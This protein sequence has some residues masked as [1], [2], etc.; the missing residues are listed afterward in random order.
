MPKKTVSNLEA[1]Q[2]SRKKMTEHERQA[3]EE[4][5]LAEREWQQREYEERRTVRKKLAEEAEKTGMVLRDKEQEE[6]LRKL[7][8][9]LG[10][11]KES[12]ERRQWLAEEAERAKAGI[13]KS[14]ALQEPEAEA[15]KIETAFTQI[16]EEWFRRGE[17]NQEELEEIYQRIP[18]EQL[19]MLTEKAE[20]STA[21]RYIQNMWDE[22]SRNLEHYKQFLTPQIKKNLQTARKAEREG[23]EAVRKRA[24]ESVNEHILGLMKEFVAR[25]FQMTD[26]FSRQGKEAEALQE[27]ADKAMGRGYYNAEDAGA[28]GIFGKIKRRWKEFRI[29][30]K[31]SGDQ[32][33]EFERASLGY[34]GYEKSYRVTEE[35][36][37]KRFGGLRDELERY[38]GIESGSILNGILRSRFLS[39]GQAVQWIKTR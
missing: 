35:E 18:P 13:K 4:R 22:L 11:T 12:R 10:L 6:R 29:K 27:L 14:K 9:E 7:R 25:N 20:D 21:E 28:K 34:R 3:W 24:L 16:E 26:M 8:E 32:R 23:N 2:K 15:Q 31:L 33:K 36:M 19:E 39:H 37:N 1:P 17:T 30:S 38:T 5:E